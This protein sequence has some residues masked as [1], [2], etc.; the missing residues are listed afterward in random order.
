ML[1]GPRVPCGPGFSFMDQSGQ[2]VAFFVDGFNLYHAIR[3]DPSRRKYKWLDLRQLCRVLIGPRPE[4][5]AVLYFTAFAY[6]NSA[7]VERHQRYIKALRQSD[8]RIIH[9]EFKMIDRKCRLCERTYKTFEEK[10]TDVNIAVHL[11]Q[12]AL[13]DEYDTAILVSGDT[14]LAPSIEAIHRSFPSKRIEIAVP[15]GRRAKLLTQV[16]DFHRKIKRRHLESC[17]FPYE[18]ELA[19]GQKVICPERWR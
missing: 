1:R 6:W 8:V 3:S 9:G 17:Q 10:Q 19:D 2:R 13:R 14:D 16:A 11:F 7:K 18:L 4:I 12:L 15:P 5:S